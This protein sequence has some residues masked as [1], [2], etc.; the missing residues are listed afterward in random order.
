MR[1]SS[2]RMTAN[3]LY[4]GLNPLRSAFPLQPGKQRKHG[5]DHREEHFVDRLPAEI[6][7]HLAGRER[8]RGHASENEKII[9][10]LNLGPLV[11]AVALGPHCS[12]PDA[13]A[14]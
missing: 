6:G 10:R 2:A 13:E 1:A 8:S 5:E 12:R 3:R 4:L 11:C 14:D 9:E 7:E